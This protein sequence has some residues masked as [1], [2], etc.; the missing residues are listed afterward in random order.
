MRDT[1]GN[2]E[3]ERKEVQRSVVTVL[4]EVAAGDSTHPGH[5]ERA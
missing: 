2:D 5:D 1:H 3:K 4:V